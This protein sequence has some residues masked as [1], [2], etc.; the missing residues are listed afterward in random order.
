MSDFLDQETREQL[1]VD[2]A[3]ER[4][5]VYS[6]LGGKWKTKLTADLPSDRTGWEADRADI[7]C[8]Q[9]ELVRGGHEWEHKLVTAVTKL[10]SAESLIQ[11]LKLG[12]VLRTLDLLYLK[13]WMW[14]G[15][16]IA[17]IVPHAAELFAWWPSVD[18]NECLQILNP[19][20]AWAPGFA[21]DDAY[22]PQLGKLRARR[23]ELLSQV[24]ALRREQTR[25][26]SVKYNRMPNRERAYVWE[27]NDLQNLRQAVNDTDLRLR[28]ETSWEVVY[29]ITDR[30]AV[31]QLLVQLEQLADQIADLELAVLQDVS[32]RL[33]VYAERFCEVETAWGRLDWLLTR[34]VAARKLGWTFPVLQPSVWSLRDAV[35]PRLSDALVKKGMQPTPVSF[36]LHPG[37]SVLVGP[38]MGG[39]TVALKAA[40]LL[41]ALAQSGMPVPAAVYQFDFVSRIRYIGGDPQSMEDGLSS[42]GGEVVRIAE[43]A[44]TA[45]AAPAMVLLDEVGRATNPV[46]GEALAVAMVRYLQSA[47][48]IVFFATHY[49]GVAQQTGIS[50]WQVAGF[51]DYRIISAVDITVKQQALQIAEQ[52]G[53][54]TEIVGLARDWLCRGRRNHD[55]QTASRS[56][57]D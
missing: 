19:G 15:Y 27:R 25:E 35:H 18:W 13:Q 34:I 23:R 3:L 40:G 6:E 46:E 32:R 54:P 47:P 10:R 57:T 56:G 52:L 11:Q 28:G 33:S 55:E 7:E 41:Q 39:K 51:S 22:D 5:N 37:V 12:T 30:P 1:A 42:F 9:R 48:Q 8:L 38:N 49:A 24:D 20:E 53:L 44:R 36:D 21:V 31:A 2:C 14:N 26:L 17:L 4:F 43:V 16:Q 29:Q 45:Q 50:K